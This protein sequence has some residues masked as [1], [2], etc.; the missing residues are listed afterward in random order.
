MACSLCFPK[1]SSPSPTKCA[2]SLRSCTAPSTSVVAT[3]P[4]RPAFFPRS[5]TEVLRNSHSHPF[6]CSPDWLENIPL[7]IFNMF[8]MG[9]EQLGF[10]VRGTP[11]AESRRSA[12]QS[13]SGHMAFKSGI[14]GR[15]EKRLPIA[16]VV[17]LM[18]AQDQPA[19]GAE[20]TYTDNVTAHV[21]PLLPNR[22][23]QPRQ[24][25][26]ATPLTD[27]T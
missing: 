15:M 13:G 8:S 24:P 27:Q 3:G 19:N 7:L 16:I 18:D 4:S 11:P 26:P 1:N 14:V 2:K 22:L 9:D 17:R 12:P 6:R 10:T 25:P 5:S 20:L 21:A 23:F